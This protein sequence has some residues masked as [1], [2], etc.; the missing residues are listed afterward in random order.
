MHC[1][2]QINFLGIINE[3]KQYLC[4]IWSVGHRDWSYA[5]FGALRRSLRKLLSRLGGSDRTDHLKP[6]EHLS[7]VC[8]KVLIKSRFAEYQYH[9]PF[10]G[11][12]VRARSFRIDLLFYLFIC[13]CWRFTIII[14]RCEILD[15]IRKHAWGP[16]I[17]SPEDST[18]Y[19]QVPQTNLLRA[20]APGEYHQGRPWL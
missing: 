4:M 14:R 5:L 13:H 20:G 19:R 6:K 16:D 1:A 17:R 11:T 12:H 2:I 3:L 9:Q 15:L 8:N 10:S 18:Q 7:N